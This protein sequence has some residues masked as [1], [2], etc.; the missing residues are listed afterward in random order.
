MYATQFAVPVDCQSLLTNKWT[1]QDASDVIDPTV[2]K[3]IWTHRIGAFRKYSH[4]FCQKDEGR[5]IWTP[6]FK[7]DFHFPEHVETM[8]TKWEKQ[9]PLNYKEFTWLFLMSM[10][11]SMKTG[12]NQG[13]RPRY[14]TFI[15]DLINDEWPNMR[16]LVEASIA[17]ASDGKFT[18][19]EGLWSHLIAEWMELKSPT[20]TVDPQTINA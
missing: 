19:L 14:K 13:V 10:W 2:D 18:T 17:N 9:I 7:F 12:M 6:E 16:V 15:S 4:Y 1:R 20:K 8:P 11:V 3:S 5:I